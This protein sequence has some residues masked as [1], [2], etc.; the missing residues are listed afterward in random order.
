[1]K[2]YAETTTVSAYS[3]G[4]LKILWNLK[5]LQFINLRHR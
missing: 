4:D 2:E 5:I 1:M 3:F